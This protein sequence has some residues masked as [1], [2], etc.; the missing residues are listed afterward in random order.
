MLKRN[1]YIIIRKINGEYIQLKDPIEG[2]FS[3]G[4]NIG[5]LE[6][7]RKYNETNDYLLIEIQKIKNPEFKSYIIIDVVAN[8]YDYTFRI[9]INRYI[10]NTF[11]NINNRTREKNN[12]HINIYRLDNE[13]QALIELST[14]YDE[15]EIKFEPDIQ[16]DL[17]NVSGFK[18]YRILDKNLNIYFS[19]LN[20]KNR[21][22]N[23]MIRYYYTQYEDEYEYYFDDKY[24]LNEI[25]SDKEYVSISLTF[26]SI[27]IKKGAEREEIIMRKGI[28]FLITGILYRH[29]D[30][31]DECIN[32][33]SILTNHEK[34][35]TNNTRHNYSHDNPEKWTL[36]F[37][38]IP[39]N[40][41]Y[42]YDLQLQGRI[43]II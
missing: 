5:Y 29:N 34:Y 17:N 10:F 3:N 9:P 40:N 26:N 36:T 41:N 11:N 18:K 15:I 6:I 39:R 1:I 4:F 22:T 8:E 27:K 24:E 32:T 31:T 28:Y 21:D 38:N 25:K 23:Y 7:I 16:F 35:F 20:P 30:T 19:V 14:Q 42:V 37:D 12:Y 2:Y 43:I 33:A 13:S